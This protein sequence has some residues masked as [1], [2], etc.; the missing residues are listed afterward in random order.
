MLGKDREVEIRREKRLPFVFP[1]LYPVANIIFSFI[2]CIIYM[3]CE[4]FWCD[5][6][7]FVIVHPFLE[8]KVVI[9]LA[10]CRLEG[11]QAAYP[12]SEVRE[13]FP[14]DT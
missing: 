9:C 5:K 12:L 7:G 8:V 4:F 11:R 3:F 14:C 13:H 2:K 6:E 10:S 1:S